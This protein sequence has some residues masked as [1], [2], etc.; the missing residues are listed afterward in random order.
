MTVK[1][2]YVSGSA[3]R[4]T[5]QAVALAAMAALL[6]ACGG[7][8]DCNSPPAFEGGPV[9]DC[10]QGGNTTPRAAD[11]SIVLSS[12]SLPND[13]ASRITA[14]A[15]AVDSNSNTVQG[16]PVTLRVNNNARAEVS[17]PNTDAAG[18]VVAL[19]NSDGDG[20][21][22][23]VTV[24]AVSGGLSRT[25]TFRV[26]G[27]TLKANPL[28]AVIVP[29]AAGRVSFVLSN[30]NSKPMSGQQ[31]TV[32][33]SDGGTA[34]GTTDFNGEFIYSYIASVTPGSLNV[35]A[36][37][38]GESAT[39]TVLVQS[40]SGLIPPAAIAVQSAS[41][42]TSV[43]VVPI[44]SGN[45]SNRSELRALFVGANNTAVRNVRVRFDLAGDANAVGGT[46]TT[47]SDVV[48]S[49]INGVATSNYEP[50][51]RSSPTDGLTVRACWSLNDFAAG[52]CP[53]QATAQLTV[54]SDTVSITIGDDAL[55]QVENESYVKTFLVQV[56]DSS[57]QAKAGVRIS[58]S[59]DLVQYFKGEWVVVGD[60]WAKTQRASCGN[61]DLNRNGVLQVYS[62]GA[63]EDANGTGVLEPRK[64]DVAF[65]FV[66]SSSTDSK[67][68]LRIRIAYPQN[69]A[70]W[71]RYNLQVV[72]GGVSGTEGRTNYS[73]VLPVLADAISDPD[74]NPAFRRSPYGTEA[75]PVVT[76]TNPLGQS[77]SLCTNP[78]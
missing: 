51:S 63:V 57:G 56:V 37:S 9:G 66:G 29:G 17:G 21:S 59:I 31:I 18:K 68:Q 5:V 34:T 28:P 25:A 40:G 10:Q 23:T 1:L 64:A 42:A 12:N 50:A 14:T 70:S 67:G 55:L 22:R 38:G 43:S 33:A 77:A 13:G 48:Y 54:V 58:P 73:D 45:T 27:A 78:N 3:L 75:S 19:I 8:S 6:V 4:R 32:T 46:I 24:T 72:A 26:T 60:K 62:N 52:A 44:N 30:V 41:L 65:S 7:D 11:L 35:S 39:T 2:N 49:D 20:A 76:T 69:V 16:I 74:I 47:G 53:N 36:S 61:E 71:V 15:V